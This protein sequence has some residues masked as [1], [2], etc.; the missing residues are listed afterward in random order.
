MPKT[1]AAQPAKQTPPLPLFAPI[2]PCSACLCFQSRSFCPAAIRPLLP[3]RAPPVAIPD[4][5]VISLSVLSS[6]RRSSR[7]LCHSF[8]I[9]LSYA[10]S[11]PPHALIYVVRD[12]EHTVSKLIHHHALLQ[13]VDQTGSTFCLDPLIQSSRH[14]R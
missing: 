3:Y 14:Y 11:Q 12:V 9:A 5:L 4:R 2:I 6:L 13:S 8:P 1:Q 10:G 7:P